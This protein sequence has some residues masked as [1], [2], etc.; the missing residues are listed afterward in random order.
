MARENPLWGYRR[1][2]GELAGLGYR[3]APSTV[4]AIL[5]A[6]GIDPAPQRSG[7]TWAQ[8]L[9]AQA[10]TIVAAD[11]FHVDTAFL[12]RLYV[13]FVIEHGTRRVHLAGITAHP[14]GAWAAQ[15][16]RNLLMNLQEQPGAV[17]W[18]FLIRDRDAKY[19]AAFDTVF[20]A[21]GMRTI[22][23]PVRAPRANAIAERWILSVRHECLDRILIT[24]P[25]HLHAVLTEYIDHHNGHRP[26]RSLNQTPPNGR[27]SCPPVTDLD[28]AG[29]LRR[30]RLGGLI[31]EYSQVA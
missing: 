20:T 18:K 19:T 25:R 9:A 30:D 29:V 8:F 31:H 26:H 23:T 4:W 21:I 24:G 5:K 13:L 22:R 6:A 3:V 27:V 14:T 12:R 28:T 2:T 10:K 16:A 7:P 11:F 15:Q 17:A 1:I